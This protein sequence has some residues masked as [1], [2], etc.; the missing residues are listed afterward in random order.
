MTAK[1][2]EIAIAERLADQAA[3]LTADQLPQAVRA[4]A[5]ELLVDVIGLCVAARNT[6]YVR[7][8]VAGVDAG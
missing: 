7:A 4:R 6:D 8:I 2:P 5:E 1:L 3:A